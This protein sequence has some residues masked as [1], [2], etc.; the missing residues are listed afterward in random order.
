MVRE[1]DTAAVSYCPHFT[2]SSTL[3]SGGKVAQMLNAEAG[4]SSSRQSRQVAIDNPSFPC[5]K[6]MR[7]LREP[8][9]SMYPLTVHMACPRVKGQVERST[10]S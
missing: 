10:L 3:E 5:G 8:A 9:Y 7:D 2:R 6:S 4:E 1:A